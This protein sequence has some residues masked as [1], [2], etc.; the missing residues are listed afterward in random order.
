MV[1]VFRVSLHVDPYFPNSLSVRETFL[2]VEEKGGT[3]V[4]ETSGLTLESEYLLACTK[5]SVPGEVQRKCKTGELPH[6]HVLPSFFV[7]QI[8]GNLRL[9]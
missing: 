4:S 1:S 5:R 9:S 6:L 8:K 2:V 3:S 7:L